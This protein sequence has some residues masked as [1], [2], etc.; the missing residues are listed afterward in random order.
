[1]L[2]EGIRTRMRQERVGKGFE[3]YTAG[4]EFELGRA[5]LVRAWNS[6]SFTPSPGCTKCAFRGMRFPRI[7]KKKIKCWEGF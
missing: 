6:R 1:M 5:S 2:T 3:I 7:Q 4:L